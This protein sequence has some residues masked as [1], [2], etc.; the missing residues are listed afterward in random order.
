[1]TKWYNERSEFDY[2]APTFSLRT[3]HFT[4]LVWLETDFIGV[5]RVIKG[6]TAYVVVNYDPPGN[7]IYEGQY[8]H[9][10]L[11]RETENNN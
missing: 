2:N 7:I 5:G 4:Q 11:P 9:N 1:M 3:G 6:G 8:E 10:V